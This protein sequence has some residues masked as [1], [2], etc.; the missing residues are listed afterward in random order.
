[1]KTPSSQTN[2]KRPPIIVVMG[3][4]DH[5]K[6]T[7]LDCIRKCNT[8]AG[9]PGGINQHMGAYETSFRDKAG[10][11]HRL[12]FLDTPGHEAFSAI[13]ARGAKTADI[14]VLVVSA[15]DGVKPQTLEALKAIKET[16][17]PF[18]V[19]INKIDRP[20]V[21]IERIKANLAEHEVYLEGYGGDISFVPVSAVTGQGVPELLE[22]LILVAEF[23]GLHADPKKTAEGVVIEAHVD[24]KRGTTATLV[25][26]DGTLTTGSFLVSGDSFTPVR[27]IENYL[28]KQVKAAPPSCPVKIL[29]W[30]KLP[31]AG[32]TFKTLPTKK[33]AEAEVLLHTEKPKN[34]ELWTSQTDAQAINHVI[35]PLVIK[36]DA[37]GSLDAVLQEINKI[38]VEGV[39]FRVLL[40][41]VGTISENDMRT[42][43]AGKSPL[44]LGFNVKADAS[45]KA[46]AERTAI[47]IETF[48]IIYRLTEW[49]RNECEKRRPRIEVEEETGRAKI[50][51]LFSS[52]KNKY[53]VGGRVETGVIKSGSTVKILRREIEIA[54]GRIRSLQQLKMKADEVGKDTEFGAMIE[55]KIEPAP[56]DRIIAFTVTTK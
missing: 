13:R 17:I 41:G 2:V 47:P 49:V 22:L 24:H 33:E 36:A 54:T 16:K 37:A 31:K 26:R 8:T 20:G 53:V 9:E 23:A 19:A 39:S 21:N 42:A 18:V 4:I 32:G 27:S 3:H 45:A 56:G 43:S 51:K 12:T 44:I 10:T 48:N 50:L 40:A 15:E 6:S 38:S 30:N 55:S 34:T 14:A 46:I 28:G 11:E 5:G 7:L 52:D 35:I 1:M 29:G 25:V